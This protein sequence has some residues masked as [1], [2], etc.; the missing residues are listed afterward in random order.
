MDIL[1][2]VTSIKSTH[3]SIALKLT[4]V[5]VHQI[6]NRSNITDTLEKKYLNLMLNEWA[7]SKRRCGR[8]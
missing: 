3:D 2:F 6:Q 1:C 5:N 4:V 8:V 7:N